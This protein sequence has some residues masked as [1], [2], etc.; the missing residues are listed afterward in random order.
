MH[1]LGSHLS[2]A[3]VRGLQRWKNKSLRT[4][5]ELPFVSVNQVDFKTTLRRFDVRD[6]KRQAEIS[7]NLSAL[8]SRC[9]CDPLQQNHRSISVTQAWIC[10]SRQPSFGVV[11]S[12]FSIYF[13]V[14][15]HVGHFSSDTPPLLSACNSTSRKICQLIRRKSSEN[16]NQKSLE[17]ATLEKEGNQIFFALTHPNL[18]RKN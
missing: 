10:L 12:Y 15:S 14:T 11:S 2:Y 8:A 7:D 3:A 13:Y 5:Q 9:R 17:T 4:S 1:L 6:T 16:S 18:V